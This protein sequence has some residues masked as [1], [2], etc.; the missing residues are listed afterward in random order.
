MATIAQLMVQIGANSS[1]L[2]RELE[3]SK[4]S[5]KRAF[6]DDA[7][8]ASQGAI[9]ILAGL[10]AA[11]GAVGLAGV[12]MAAN[13]EQTKTAFTTMLG[14]AQ[15]AESFLKQLSDF[16]AKTPFELPGLIDSSKKMLAFGFSA[17]QVIP[18]LTAVGDASAALG[19]G[20][21]GVDRVTIALGQMQAKGKVSAEEMMQL[22]ENGI[23]AWEM[24]ANAIGTSIPDAMDQV[25]K[26]TVSA[27]T[28]I[29]ALVEGMNARF[30][31]MME[32][33]SSNMLGML[34]TAA[35]G[36]KTIL[37]TLGDEIIETFDL[38]NKLKG[39]TDWISKFAKSVETSGIKQSMREMIPPEVKLVILAISGAIVGA[40]VPALYLLATAAWAAMAPLLPFIA[41]GAAIA[42]VAYFIWENWEPFVAWW[43]SAWANMS[44]WVQTATANVKNDIAD[45]VDWGMAKIQ[46]LLN[47]IDKLGSSIGLKGI[48]DGINNLVGNA[49]DKLRSSAEY[50]EYMAAVNKGV[51]GI[52]RVESTGKSKHTKDGDRATGREA[53]ATFK[54]VQANNDYANSA[55]K[56]AKAA[57]SKAKGMDEAARKAK[58]LAE[59]VASLSEQIHDDYVQTTYSDRGQLEVWFNEQKAHLDELKA[60]NKNYEEDLR[61]LRASYSEKR[62]KIAKDEAEFI[63]QTFKE[64]AEKSS[65]INL[66][67]K[68]F[69][70]TGSEKL[71]QDIDEEKN[72]R[73][74]AV[75]EYMD[76]VAKKQQEVKEKY[77]TA[78]VSGVD[79]ELWKKKYEEINQVAK[80][81]AERR[82]EWET[83][84]A[85]QTQNKVVEAYRTGQMLEADIQAA[86]QQHKLES[87]MTLL[88]DQN[89]Y[90]LSY[91]EGQQAVMDTYRELQLEAN[92]SM[93]SYMAEAAKT[94]YNELTDA[95]TGLLDGSKSLSQAIGDLGKAMVNMIIRFM[96]QKAA[97]SIAGKLLSKAALA[98]DKAQ[99]VATAA[100]WAPAAALASLATSGK[101]AIAANAGIAATT[102]FAMSMAN[103]PACAN[104]G[105]TTG[106]TLALIGEGRYK[107]AVLPLDKDRLERLGLGGNSKQ[108]A[109]PVFQIHVSA[110][111][112]D[113]V[114]RLFEEKGEAIVRSLAKQA[115]G[116]NFGGAF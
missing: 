30:G 74:K 3:A 53:G 101:N 8:G 18:M 52:T 70:Q 16:A 7:L 110:F 57:K 11:M 76:E 68:T 75:Q 106:P 37:R 60:H 100:A 59:K 84:I 13:M 48:K 65:D 10:G 78:K 97:A 15:A 33:Q 51:A 104:G 105:I 96:A 46:P 107:E 69:N 89:A 88:E 79:V 92:R 47:L 113:S 32:K 56:A 12:K 25:S 99:A 83:A 72:D 81:A 28:G 49:T 103:V 98:D 63:K 9:G 94:L 66:N 73:L 44:S 39:A 50:N 19:I 29:N 91:L 21:E 5:I 54:A 112:G 102:T 116:F 38:K 26:G 24:L 108:Q 64:L 86:Y 14:S 111:D 17:E 35:D 109:S 41:V 58:E 90:F 77:D 93:L 6:G 4:R 82:G 36:A 67:V 43:K 55:E 31:G 22:A 23:P 114:E 1:G 95:F 115:R 85:Q 45:M 2:R 20:A 27:S 34:S 42:A 80:E 87:Y 61:R 40:A 62:R 71:L